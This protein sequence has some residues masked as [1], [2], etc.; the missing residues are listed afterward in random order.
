MIAAR[1]VFFRECMMPMF[2]TYTRDVLENAQ[3]MAEGL[4]DGGIRLVT[5][6]TD[7]HLILADVGKLGLTGAAA[8]EILASLGLVANKNPIPFDKQPAMVGSGIRLG[9]PAITT[10]GFE[11]DDCH[12][13]GAMVADALT[14]RDDAKT[15]ARI[16]VRVGELASSH[17]LFHEKWLPD[18][19]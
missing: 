5:G 9:S 1:A 3:A 4:M 19:D 10:R 13:V 11:R 18:P 8:E 15:M 2:R 12:E 17:P 6:G 16:A 14:Q 7:T